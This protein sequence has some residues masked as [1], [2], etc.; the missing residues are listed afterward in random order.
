MSDGSLRPRRRREA[1]SLPG[2]APPPFWECV[3]PRRGEGAGGEE[4]GAAGRVPVCGPVFWTA[5]NCGGERLS[6]G[7]KKKKGEGKK[8]EGEDKKAGCRGEAG[9]VRPPGAGW[10]RAVPGL[11]GAVLRAQPGGAAV[12]RQA[13]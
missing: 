5:F 2:G 9:L 4:R 11:W 6:Q 7:K 10:P 3:R 13:W 8:K 12:A 1:V